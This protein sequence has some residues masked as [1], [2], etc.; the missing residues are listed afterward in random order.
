MP[1]IP[2]DIEILKREE[3][4]RKYN[5]VKPKPILK[6]QNPKTKRK[7]WFKRTTNK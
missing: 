4:N 6:K 2:S 7:P 1:F 5:K 3:E